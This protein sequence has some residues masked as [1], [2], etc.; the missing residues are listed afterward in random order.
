MNLKCLSSELYCEWQKKNLFIE[1]SANPALF[2]LV[3]AKVNN[4]GDDIIRGEEHRQTKVLR[5]RNKKYCLYQK[6]NKIRK[7]NLQSLSSEKDFF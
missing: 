1:I 6:K 3:T 7:T 4:F 5:K 2:E